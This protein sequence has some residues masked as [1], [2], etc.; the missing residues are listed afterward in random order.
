MCESMVL[1]GEW[2]LIT[3]ISY[4]GKEQPIFTNQIKYLSQNYPDVFLPGE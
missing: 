3:Y 1:E 2:L 4:S